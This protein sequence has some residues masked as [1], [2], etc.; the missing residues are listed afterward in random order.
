MQRRTYL[1]PAV[2]L[3]LLL[4][5]LLVIPAPAAEKDEIMVLCGTSFGPPTEKLIEMFKKETGVT[6]VISLDGSEDLLP[7]VKD[8]EHCFLFCHFPRDLHLV[9]PGRRLRSRID[10]WERVLV[11]AVFHLAAQSRF[12]RFH[13]L[14][15]CIG[16]HV[17]LDLSPLRYPSESFALVEFIAHALLGLVDSLAWRLPVAVRQ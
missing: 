7:Q 3:T 6:A 11:R 17:V 2:P 1:P 10:D 14:S 13:S 16:G 15:E 9:D 4:S 8:I 12:H 5:T